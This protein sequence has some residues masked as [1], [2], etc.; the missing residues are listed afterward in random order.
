MCAH[1][2]FINTRL[3]STLLQK[4]FTKAFS[5]IMTKHYY[6]VNRAVDNY[7]YGLAATAAQAARIIYDFP[8]QF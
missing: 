4:M 3:S 1:K 6:Y 5:F 8:S 7:L 2:V